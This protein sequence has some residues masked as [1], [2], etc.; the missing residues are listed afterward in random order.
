MGS[1]VSLCIRLGIALLT[2][3]VFIG[4]YALARGSDTAW[5]ALIYVLVPG[6]LLTFVG[7]L[8]AFIESL[9]DLIGLPNLTTVTTWTV[10]V[11]VI[12]AALCLGQLASTLVELRS[13][14]QGVVVRKSVDPWSFFPIGPPWVRYSMV[15]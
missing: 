5:P 7:K 14:Y 4:I 6:L 2:V 13:G 9:R 15:V 1:L 12:V 11:L 3:A 8:L 10:G